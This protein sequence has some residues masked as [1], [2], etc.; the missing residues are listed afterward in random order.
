MPTLRYFRR[1]FLAAA[2]L[3]AIAV[4]AGAADTPNA[5]FLVATREL[6]DPNFEKTVV[7][8]TYPPSG[9][10]FG[11]IIN[12]PLADR[13]AEAMPDQP[14]LKG[15]KDV[16]Y[17]GGPVSREGLV[18]L[19]RGPNPPPG[20]L[21]VLP[22]VFFTADADLIESLLQRKNPLDGVRV[23]AGYSGWGPGQLQREIARGDW[24]V[25]PADS[26]TVFDK[27]PKWI[28]PEMIDR[29]TSK[30]TNYPKT[31]RLLPPQGE[32]W[33]GGGV[34]VP[35]RPHPHPAPAEGGAGFHRLHRWM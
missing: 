27:D 28:W 1:F 35:G 23:F 32:G 4:P 20:A 19:V 12:R 6:L 9:T 30:Q 29:A 7:L 14:A 24:R 11:V 17:S 15:R 16:L 31:L 18:F 13:L 5:I 10:P 25:L 26:K 2:A 8:V 3:A 33:D 34:K 21:L 22:D